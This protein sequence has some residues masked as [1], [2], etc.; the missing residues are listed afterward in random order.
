MNEMLRLVPAALLVL[1]GSLVA[2]AGVEP[3]TPTDATEVAATIS[4]PATSILD[5]P[6]FTDPLAAALDELYDLRFEDAQEKL[7]ALAAAHPRHPAAPLLRALP[8][9]F[10]ILLDV[11]DE[12]RDTSFL[13]FLDTALELSKERLKENPD[14]VDGR[15]F[16]AAALAFRAR[17]KILRDAYLPAARDG[18]KAL[19][20]VRETEGL[21]PDLADVAFGIGVYDYAAAVFPDRYPM[22]KPVAAFFP[23]GDRRRGIELLEN[24]VADGEFTSTEAA[25]FLLQV[26]HFYEKDYA[27]TLRY[28]RWLRERHPDN[29]LFHELEGRVYLRYDRC[30]D[31][32]R[33]FDEVLARAEA[34][35]PG[36][37]R[38]RT[39]R[40]HYSLGRCDLKEDRGEDALTRLS[41]VEEL[42]LEHA[43]D[44]PLR[45][46][47]ML[48]RGQ[49]YDLLGRRGDAVRE[50]N[51]VLE[52]LDTSSAHKKARRW[53]GRPYEAGQAG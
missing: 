14:D 12:S 3:P 19:K 9:Y 35:R 15:F 34:G 22:L 6:G 17:H 42:S 13:A 47:G 30:N 45:T 7:A 40:A 11:S 4:F 50:Y 41:L 44:S 51:R 28:A 26:H 2:H 5:D 27:R 46:L 1:L 33:I 36:Y 24:A 10:H 25:F 8:D 29:P 52:R 23:K 43:P 18:K 37:N 49:A 32:R 53:L 16:Q 21:R 20:L 48:R 31:A 39:V 38:Y